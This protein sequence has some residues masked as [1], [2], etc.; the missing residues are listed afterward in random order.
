MMYLLPFWTQVCDLNDQQTKQEEDFMMSTEAKKVFVE[1][2]EHDALK[3][4]TL[5]KQEIDRTDKAWRPYWLR[6]A[7]DIQQGIEHAGFR[8]FLNRS[9]C[10]TEMSE[11]Y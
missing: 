6:V 2:S 1:L 7:E 11:K 4:V 8:A 5:I 9:V 10:R 3:L